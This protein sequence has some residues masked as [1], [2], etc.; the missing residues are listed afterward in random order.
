MNLMTP[1][2]LLISRR[3]FLAKASL[4]GLA[5]Q[6]KRLRALADSGTSVVRT[7]SGSLRGESADAV[8]IFRGIPFAEPPVGPLRFRPT[9]PNKPWTGERD[10]TRFAAS[11]MQWSEATAFGEQPFV[12]SEDCLYL[13]I[14]APEGK[15]PFPV[16]VWIHGGGYISGHAFGPIHN[17]SEFARQGIMSVTLPYRLGVLGFLDLGPLLG[18]E[19]N[20]SANN[21]LRDLITALEWIQQNISAFGGDPA[22][23]TIGGESAG[24]KLTDILMGT[25]SARPLFRQMISESGGAERVWSKAGSAAVARGYGEQWSKK[26]GL[27]LAGLKTA[28]AD[29]LI[30][31]QHD[32]LTEWPQ[33]FPL[34]PEIDDQLLPQLPVKTI[35]SGSSQGK[36]L[37]IGTNR[38]ESALF[39]G[40]HPETDPAPRDLGNIP[41]AKFD[42]VLQ[43]YKQAYPEMKDFQTRI[44]AVT[45]EEYWVP[46]IRVADALVQGGGT[47]FMYRLDFTESSGRLSGF[48]YHSLD[49]PLVWDRPHP[50]A[51]NVVAETELAKQV[52]LAWASFIR[53]DTPA[54]P[55]LPAW[56]EYSIATRPTMILDTE[57]RVEQKPNEAE[58]RLWDGVF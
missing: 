48:A 38:D 9:V 19:Y 41:L 2:N 27:D 36:R 29:T 35:A 22:R 51:A 47:A 16:F 18:P 30:A 7:P 14:W 34:R 26:T 37:L 4:A 39:I 21:A 50:N 32:F 40:P 23:V 49:V 25:P 12:H 13:N 1:E 43:R 45:A 46:S 42:P 44:R 24:A 56:P 20:G 33:H 55:R 17:G 53:G 58:L 6:T 8:R 15:G 5:L 31:A 52:H 57:S 28:P 54:A 3:A 10:A 11:A